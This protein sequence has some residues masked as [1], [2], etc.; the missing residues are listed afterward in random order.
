MAGQCA[1][2]AQ[3]GR[4][5]ADH[6]DRR[7]ARAGARRHAAE[8]DHRHRPRRGQMGQG[9][10]ADGSAVARR[11]RDVR[12][13]IP[14]GADHPLRR[15]YLAHRRF[16]RHGAVGAAPQAQD[17]RRRRRQRHGQRA[18]AETR[19]LTRR[20][21]AM[22]R[23]AYVNGRYLPHREASVHVE[24]RGFQFAD[25]VYEVIA[26]KDGSFVDE[27]PHL[28]QLRRS[29][30]EMRMTAPMSDAALKSVMRETVRR[31]RVKDGIL[32]LQ[33]TRGSAP[34]DFAF[35]KGA[36]PSLIMTARAQKPLDP[37]I[38]SEGVAV[39]TLPD[40]R[41]AR[42]DIKSVALLPNALA[43]QRAKEA[44]AYEAWQVDR[45]GNVTE[46]TSSNARIVTPAGQVVTRQAD[47]GILN[48]VPRQD[49]LRVVAAS[50]LRIS[51]RP[52][53]V[54]EAKGA[55]EALL[56]SSTNFILPVVT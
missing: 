24:D 22:S 14:A 31:N 13:R 35:P 41:W 29:L 28:A 20:F 21:A 34:R 30:G 56:T 19:R 3:R 27:A 26:V 51:E 6:G 9:R 18:P 8:R 16:R 37:R 7:R 17:P 40:I 2:A 12:A 46:G 15:Q 11:A 47:R 45:D 52:F 38:F 23:I 36:K 10:R 49:L 32:Y 4:L 53:S 50:G 42:P 5:G 43:K 54:A 44:G 55:A 39:V 33:V 48:G 1:P 25:G